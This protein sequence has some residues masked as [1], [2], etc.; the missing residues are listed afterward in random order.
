MSSKAA[1]PTVSQPASSMAIISLISGVLGLTLL[2]VVGSIAAVITAILARREIRE[3]AGALGGDGLA[4][5]GLVL[6]WIGVALTVIGL[7]V[8]G[9][10]VALPLCLGLFAVSTSSTTS[11][12][13]LLV[14]LA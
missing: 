7:C 2:P 10:L 13:P 9:V 5:A 4:T 3:S 6:G 11:W 8:F 1:P 14:T 12:L